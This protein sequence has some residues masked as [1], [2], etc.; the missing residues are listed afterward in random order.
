VFAFPQHLQRSFGFL[1]QANLRTPSGEI[2]GYNHF[3][4][5]LEKRRFQKVAPQLVGRK[6]RGPGFQSRIPMAV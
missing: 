5:K 2:R 6:R 4:R 3:F 1:P